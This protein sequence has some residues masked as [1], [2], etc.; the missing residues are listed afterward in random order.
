MA[1]NSDAAA[2]PAAAAAAATSAS[3]GT[4]GVVSDKYTEVVKGI[5]YIWNNEFAE[6]DKLFAA[7]KDSDP[8]YA[9]HHAEVIFL[10]SFITADTADTASALARLEAARHLATTHIAVTH[11][12][13]FVLASVRV[14]RS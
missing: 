5:N 7:K 6:A 2:A 11:E 9:L 10:K 1:T 4:A 14:A 8:R 13:F 3:A 12:R